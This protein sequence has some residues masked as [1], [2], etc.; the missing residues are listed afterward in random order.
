M[1]ATTT[2]SPHIFSEIEPDAITPDIQNPEFGFVDADEELQAIANFIKNKIPYQSEIEIE[3]IKFLYCDKPKKDAGKYVAGYLIP[4]SEME[5]AVN[6]NY[7][8]IVCL[9]YH[10]WKGLDAKQKVIQLDK[11]LCGIH[12]EFGMDERKV[13]KKQQADLKE[14]EKCV[15]HFGADEVM[16]SSEIIDLAVASAREKQKEDIKSQ[17]A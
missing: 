16:K 3:R 2:F 7:D 11:I 9:Y 17:K 4:R 15:R 12:I 6:D 13:V 8:Y 5:R 10:A 1:E 14:F